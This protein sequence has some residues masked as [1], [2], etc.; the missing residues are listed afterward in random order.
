MIYI[1]SACVKAPKIRESVEALFR[2]G[3][4]HIELT[5]GTQRYGDLQKDLVELKERYHLSLLCHNYFPPPEKHFVLNLASLNDEIYECTFNHL[6]EAVELSK[7]IGAS[8]FAFHAGF[9]ID[10]STKEVGQKISRYKLFDREKCLSRFVKGF[11]ELL[12]LAD[13]KVKLYVENNVLSSSNSKTYEG[14]NPLML[15]SSQD[16]FEL[17]RFLPELNLL[18]DVGHL[19][20]SAQSLGNKF[21]SEL[22]ILMGESDYLHFSDND[23]LEDLNHSIQ[24]ESSIYD[25]LKGYD[26]KNKTVTLEYYTEIQDIK[27]SYELVK[28][29]QG[30]QT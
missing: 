4:N 18:L 6:K 25:S 15:T 21:S 14:Q 28:N 3:F 27:K 20:V 7:S 22:D 5:G 30:M 17:K 16:Y 23:A 1:S 24:N 9:F 12:D 2:E 10:L 19:K 8:K 29:L 13:G 26:F 11:R